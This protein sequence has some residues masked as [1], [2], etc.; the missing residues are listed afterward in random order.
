[1][2]NLK[3]IEQRHGSDSW[4]DAGFLMLAAL[5]LA[6]WAG[7]WTSAAAGKPPPHWTVQVIESPIEVVR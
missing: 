2:S 1:M 7:T 4:K 6:V 3:H 5:L